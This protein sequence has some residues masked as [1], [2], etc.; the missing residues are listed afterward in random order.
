MGMRFNVILVL[1]SM[2]KP[3]W[4]TP[5][6]T[7]IADL[8]PDAG[9]HTAMWWAEGFPGVVPEAPWLRT[10][11]TG[12]YVFGLETDTL[13]V[14]QLGPVE[15]GGSYTSLVKSVSE[16]SAPPAEL[17][18]EISANGKTYR[19]RKS[20]GPTKHTGPRVIDSGRFLQR[21]DISGLLFATDEGEE[22]NVDARFETVAWPD[23]LGMVL[24]ARPGITPIRAGDKSFGKSGGGYGL[25]GGNALEIPHS[26]QIDSPE[27]TLGFR[28]F[29]PA[30]YQVSERGIPWLV[31]KNF[32]EEHPGNYGITLRRGIPSAR[33]NIAGKD[34]KFE[35]SAA[36]GE[37]LETNAWNHLAMSYDGERLRLYVNGK[38]D[39]E[40]KVGLPRVPGNKALFFGRRGDTDNGRYRFRGV[41]DDIRIYDRALKPEQVAKDFRTPGLN[42]T[43]PS[44]VLEMGFK[45]D[46][47]ASETLTREKWMEPSIRIGLTDAGGTLN[48]KS[49]YRP[50]AET[51]WQAEDW[52]QA[53]L[54]FAPGTL[55]AV[56]SEPDLHLEVSGKTRGEPCLV[57]FDP[58]LGCHR[59]DIDGIRT[60]PAPGVAESG[61]DDIERV[62]ILISNP[63]DKQRVARLFFEKSKGGFGP[64]IGSAVTGV[65]AMIRDADGNPTGIP[66]QVS[67]NWHT[68]P[69]AGEYSGT[70]LHLITMLN[71]PPV[72]EY[73]LELTLAYGRWGGVAAA[74]Q[75]QLSLIGWGGN[76]HWSQ[77][78]LGSWG[79]SICY[80]PS[81]AQGKCS[82]TDVR[83]VM[84]HAGPDAGKW[85]WTIN[86]GGGDFFRLSDPS[87]KRI[88]HSAMRTGYPGHGPC[89]TETVFAGKLGD[90]ITHSETV[91]LPRTD[92]IVRG[93][94]RIRMQVEKAVDFS[95]FVIFQIGADTYA[96]SRE[97][98]MA[99][100]NEN[101]SHQ[102]MGDPVGR[103]YV[104]DRTCC[105]YGQGALGF[106]ARKRAQGR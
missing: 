99:Y 59:I 93:I 30:D 88:F 42:S 77:S 100:G 24:H 98:K 102:G 64:K 2:V 89:L 84:V 78:A 48:L 26:P 51:P 16:A 36:S 11:R 56:P 27:F 37:S 34:S 101:G 76:Q 49:G 20:L 40:L 90:A 19:C 65:T 21:A 81:Q 55:T 1:L 47:I 53:S 41:L 43:M 39:G 12:S 31:C 103:R 104:S 62:K 25:D 68:R 61:N 28:V 38:A 66:V 95:R 92:D 6:S 13:R 97:R 60:D 83:P 15:G 74:S 9:A 58:T 3:G 63:S 91:S 106:A 35:L 72:S 105:V 96:F 46:G 69:Q 33:L 45:E 52:N 23:R 70:W 7:R 50:T 57:V 87:G 75:A 10:V 73:E 4:A 17:S 8:M 67:K 82:I 79:E 14:S 44:P 54:T 71:L 85:G 22:L 86:V 29:L 80:E 32:H 94:Y 18:L 5:A